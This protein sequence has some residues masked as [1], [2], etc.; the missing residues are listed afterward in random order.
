M[1]KYYFSF[2]PDPKH[3]GQNMTCKA[4]AGAGALC[5]TSHSATTFR[6]DG[7]PFL[8][9]GVVSVSG[10]FLQVIPMASLL[11]FETF[12][13]ILSV[14]V[15]VVPFHLSLRKGTLTSP[16]Q[17]THLLKTQTV[18]EPFP[19]ASP[20]RGFASQGM[21]RGSRFPLPPWH[22]GELSRSLPTDRIPPPGGAQTRAHVTRVATT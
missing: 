2:S 12:L 22:A 3:Q 20:E 7:C 9:L 8:P 15:G 16:L 13:L 21:G 11:S 17:T 5:L 14:L 10:T 1:M 18:H 4:R 6:V 19:P